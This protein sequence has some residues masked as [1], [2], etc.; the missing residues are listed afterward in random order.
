MSK[1]SATLHLRPS[2]EN[3]FGGVTTDEIGSVPGNE[4][5]EIRDK[6]MQMMSF[7][8]D[9]WASL[10]NGSCH[11]GDLAC[12]HLV[13]TTA[14]AGR[15]LLACPGSHFSSSWWGVSFWA[16]SFMKAWSY[17]SFSTETEVNHTL[18]TNISS[19]S[20][21]SLIPW[22][23]SLLKRGSKKKKKLSLRAS[24]LPCHLSHQGRDPQE[25]QR[26]RILF[27]S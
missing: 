17:F 1:R 13:K 23:Q 8:A 18:L 2:Q 9:I 11:V 27:Q 20:P 10:E 3:H 16:G 26:K 4:C 6:E 15:G 14:K 24:H 21:E 25:E 12:H 22:S 7:Q 5:L 19:Q